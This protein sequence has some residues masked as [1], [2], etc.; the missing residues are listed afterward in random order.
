MSVQTSPFISRTKQGLSGTQ[1]AYAG[2]VDL[3]TDGWE[4]WMSARLTTWTDGAILATDAAGGRRRRK[5]ACDELTE[6]C[7][8]TRDWRCDRNDDSDGRRRHAGVSLA[9]IRKGAGRH[10]RADASRLVALLPRYHCGNRDGV[11]V[12]HRA[13]SSGLRRARTAPLCN[14]PSCGYLRV[15]RRTRSDRSSSTRV[16]RV[17]LAST[18]RSASDLLRSCSGDLRSATASTSSGSIR[19]ASAGARRC[20]ASAICASRRRCSLRSRSR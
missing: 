15:T 3:V 4:G 8:T 11:P 18:S 16:D 9:A 1:I 13:G 20:A 12:R 19:G 5:G 17:V 2:R 7:S 6:L 10:R 14:S